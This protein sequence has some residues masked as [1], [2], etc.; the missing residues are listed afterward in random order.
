MKKLG[1]LPDG[2]GWRY[3]GR[4]QGHRNRTATPEKPK[5]KWH[6]A[7]MGHAFVHTVID[8]HSRVAYAEV[9]DD[10][11]AVTA[12]GVLFRAV[13]W[14]SQR[15]IAVERCPT[16]AGPTDLT[17]GATHVRLSRSHSS[18]R[19]H[20][21]PKRTGRSNASTAPWPMGGPMPAA[22]GR[23]SNAA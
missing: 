16:M 9:H 4:Q 1:N 18:G 11:T 19:A 10:E 12:V 7:M 8:D 23:R 15:G 6:G 14:F 5:S 22:T 20:T 13:K 3:V 21:G 2:G 17:Y